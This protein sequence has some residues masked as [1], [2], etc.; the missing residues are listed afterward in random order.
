[1]IA[2]H[3]IAA[4]TDLGERR[5]AGLALNPAAP[6]DVLLRLLA[7]GPK[8]AR[9]TLCE[10][11]PLPD[12]VVEA[13]IA[14][15]DRSVRGRFA[16]NPHVDPARRVRLIDDPEWF[17]RALLADGPALPPHTTPA[18]LPDWAVLHMIR[19]YD[20][21]ILGGLSSR[22]VS[23]AFMWAALSH[24]DPKVRLM[25]IG[26][27]GVPEDAR[28]ALLAD[29]DDAVRKRA[30]DRLRHEDPEWVERELPARSCHARTHLLLH[31]ALG[32]KVVESVLTAPAAGD[33]RAMIARNPTLPAD[34]VA[35]L[36]ADPD[37]EVRRRVAG[38]SRLP[39][40]W[41][42]ALGADPDPSVRERI[43][44]R[45]DLARDERRTF[46]TD[47]DP[48]VRLA[49]SMDPTLTDAECAAIDYEVPLDDSFVPW[50]QPRVPGDPGAL[51][52]DA[53]S[54]HPMRRR[55]AAGDRFLPSDLVERLAT[56]DDLGVRVLLAQNHPEAPA[57]LLLRSFLEYTGPGREHLL[58]RGDFPTAGLARYAGHEDPAVRA[59]AGRDP[60][61]PAKTVDR[62]TLD[63]DPRVRAAA[64]RHPNLPP[65]RSAQLLEDGEL[66]HHAAA[67]PALD[68]AVMRRLVASPAG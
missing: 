45:S 49:A 28:Q 53:L 67:N 21:D 35:L 54:G 25:G 18:P 15:Q 42:R 22:Q 14:H 19:T 51:R 9:M 44:H 64:A 52:H 1:M 6:D 12:T 8:V 2:S 57:A 48:R 26:W 60:R 40:R 29:P 50:T 68:P 20:D 59:L 62:L 63:P 24:P 33:E 4:T 32:R 38:H 17:V 55:R 39:Q 30:R 36:S 34:V 43:A 10:D 47:P 61:T 16:R 23:T 11:R 58:D 37:A 13:V 65:A 7:D 3:R 66:A 31:G 41:R 27:R 46:A 56:D 5:L